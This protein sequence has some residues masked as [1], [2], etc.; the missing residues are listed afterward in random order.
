MPTG[1]GSRL[2]LSAEGGYRN[3]FLPQAWSD[4]HPPQRN[5]GCL[6]CGGEYAEKGLRFT[7]GEGRSSHAR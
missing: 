4:V 6:I 1:I 2:G 7:R 3:R 5:R